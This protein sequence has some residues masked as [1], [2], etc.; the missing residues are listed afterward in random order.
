MKYRQLAVVQYD[1]CLAFKFASTKSGNIYSSLFLICKFY[2]RL[3]NLTRIC[4]YKNNNYETMRTIEAQADALKRRYC[5]N[6][7][8]NALNLTFFHDM[9]ACEFAFFVRS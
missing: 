6:S 4:D 7:S 1:E 8:T 2:R 3:D 5:C 9:L